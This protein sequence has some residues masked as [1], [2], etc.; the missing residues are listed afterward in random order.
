MQEKYF[1]C[2]FQSRERECFFKKNVDR[3]SNKT[4]SKKEK[5]KFIAK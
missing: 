3:L 1:I 4:A 2:C 5:R